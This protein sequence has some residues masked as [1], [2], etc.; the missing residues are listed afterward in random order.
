MWYVDIYYDDVEL[1]R[2]G[3]NKGGE[4]LIKIWPV[5][6]S[7]TSKG[8][9]WSRVLDGI[10]VFDLEGWYGIVLHAAQYSHVVKYNWHSDT[11]NKIVF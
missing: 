4:S 6:T 10:D 9:N 11:E 2:F 5:N 7:K 1:E 8:T 3:T